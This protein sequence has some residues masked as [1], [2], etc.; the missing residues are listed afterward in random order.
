MTIHVLEAPRRHATRRR[1]AQSDPRQ[2]RAREAAPGEAPDYVITAN[3]VLDGGVRYLRLAGAGCEW[4]VD[5]GA[6]TATGST[7]QRD[8]LLAAA[9]TDVQRNLVI[10]PYAIEVVRDGAGF[11]HKSTRERI[12]AGGPTAGC[13][14]VDDQPR[15]LA[16]A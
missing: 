6:A 3:A 8:A 11:I 13:A 16:R 5:S 1:D 15:A 9:E 2:H 7:Q 12:R 14:G 4:T 10:A